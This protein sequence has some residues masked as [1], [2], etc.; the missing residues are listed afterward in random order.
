ML[1]QPGAEAAFLVAE[2]I[3]SGFEM[4]FW[5]LKW[6]LLTSTANSLLT[7]LPVVTPIPLT[8]TTFFIL[9]LNLYLVKCAKQ[10]EVTSMEFNPFFLILPSYWK[11]IRPLIGATRGRQNSTGTKYL[12]NQSFRNNVQIRLIKQW[13]ITPILFFYRLASVEQLLCVCCHPYY[14]YLGYIRVF[15][16]R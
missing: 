16:S 11:T 12:I 9:S 2:T 6:Y 5:D 4:P 15:A 10:I 1:Q 8:P 7:P 3:V 14:H 13:L